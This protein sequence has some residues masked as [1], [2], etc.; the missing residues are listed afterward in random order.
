MSSLQKREDSREDPI[1]TDRIA[2]ELVCLGI[3][4]GSLEWRKSVDPQDWSEVDI[5]CIISE[6]KNGGGA[7]QK[8]YHHL[9]KWL[10]EFLSVEWNLN[11]KPVPSMLSKLK[12]N[13][14]K[15]RVI[16]I[17]TRL[18]ETSGYQLD[19]DLDKFFSIIS[20]AYGEAI[21]EIE[22]ILEKGKK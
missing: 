9:R 2:L 13:S 15:H 6:L 3:A 14:C 8:D 20:A 16:Q 17:L 22:S 1:L 4:L 5:Q 11:S 19:M 10:L 12:R 18:K 7:K 21:P